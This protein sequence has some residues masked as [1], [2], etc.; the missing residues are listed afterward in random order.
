[1]LTGPLVQHL[2][3][4]D[5]SVWDDALLQALTFDRCERRKKFQ[6]L[7][8]CVAREL[9]RARWQMHDV[10]NNLAQPREPH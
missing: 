2:W 4:F 8:G 3:Q 5:R 7:Y 1:M 6:G 9:L 10:P